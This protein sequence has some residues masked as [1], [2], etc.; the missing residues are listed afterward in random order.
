[1]S[2]WQSPGQ[3]HGRA[4]GGG[5]EAWGWVRGTSWHS[6]NR[7]PGMQGAARAGYCHTALQMCEVFAGERGSSQEVASNCWRVR[8]NFGGF[9]R[10]SIPSQEP[11]GGRWRADMGQFLSSCTGRYE[12]DMPG[13]KER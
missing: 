1:M 9:P 7:G 11:L 2:C 4:R 5:S 13:R 8:D 10:D 3:G 12:E 6:R